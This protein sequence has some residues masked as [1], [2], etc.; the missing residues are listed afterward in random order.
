M[1][2]KGPCVS[3]ALR[4]LFDELTVCSAF[5]HDYHGGCEQA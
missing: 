4:G 1:T 2:K 3:L 5:E